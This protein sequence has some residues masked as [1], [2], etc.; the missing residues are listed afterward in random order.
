M[1]LLVKNNFDVIKMH[2]TTIKKTHIYF[3]IPSTWSLSRRLFSKT[4]QLNFLY[5]PHFSDACCKSHAAVLH[6]IALAAYH[7]QCKLRRHLFLK[8]LLSLTFILSDIQT[9]NSWFVLKHLQ[10]A[11]LGVQDQASLPQEIKNALFLSM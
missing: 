8:F 3:G 7:V 6:S 10:S 9:P 5:L 1:H 4:C 11:H 2:G